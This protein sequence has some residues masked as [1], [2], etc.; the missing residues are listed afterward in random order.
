[1]PPLQCPLTAPQSSP[2]PPLTWVLAK[3]PGW[4]VLT[5]PLT[6]PPS[7]PESSNPDS[8]PQP[9]ARLGSVGQ[10]AFTQECSGVCL[11]SRHRRSRQG[12]QRRH[13]EV[14]W[15]HRHARQQTLLPLTAQGPVQMAQGCSSPAGAPS[16]PLSPL[17]A[18]SSPQCCPP[19]QTAPSQVLPTRAQGCSFH[20]AIAQALGPTC[21]HPPPRKP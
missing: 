10:V 17:A 13:V 6:A 7:V 9:S 4:S 5:L 15:R 3:P 18:A 12:T 16:P 14:R 8:V 11:A 19:A 21:K 1:M 20:C 2:P